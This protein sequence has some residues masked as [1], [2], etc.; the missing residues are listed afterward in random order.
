MP[1]SVI[2]ACLAALLL[3]SVTFFFGVP[4]HAPPVWATFGFV[5]TYGSFCVFSWRTEEE[6]LSLGW[7]LAM[8]VRG[9]WMLLVI[10]LLWLVIILM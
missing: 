5:T 3:G 4:K 9:T 6:L 10:V 2:L 8:V 7:W 1:P